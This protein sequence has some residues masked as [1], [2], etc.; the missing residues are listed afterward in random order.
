MLHAR[1][2]TSFKERNSSGHYGDVM[3]ALPACDYCNQGQGTCDE[4]QAGKDTDT[5]SADGGT[6]GRMLLC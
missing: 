6:N 2:R 4:T 5:T 3:Q 1:S